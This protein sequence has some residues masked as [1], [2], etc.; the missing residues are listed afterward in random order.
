MNPRRRVVL[1]SNSAWSIAN[2]RGGLIRALLAAKYDVVAVAPADGHVPKIEALGIRFV[3]LAMDNKGTNPIRDFGLFLRILWLLLRKRPAMYLGYTIK[4][5]VYGGLATRLLGI[6]AINNVTG[7]GTAFIRDTWLTRVVEGLYRVGLARS[8]KVFFQNDED[9]VLFL[10]RRL[11]CPE[12]TERLPGSGVDTEWFAPEMYPI[13][14]NSLH[15][16]RNGILNP[17]FCGNDGGEG[18]RP[19]RFLLSARL[20]WDKGVGEFVEAARQLLQEGVSAEFQL[21]GFLDVESR[22]AVSRGEVEAWERE[23]VVRY[24]G[25]VVDVRP[26]ITRADCVV[27]PS[28]YREGVPRSLLEAASMA[29]PIITTDAVGCRDVVGDCVNGYLCRPRDAKDLARQMRRM[30]ALSTEERKKM[31]FAGRKKMVLEFDEKIVIRRYLETIQ[32]NLGK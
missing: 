29:K 30:M 23:G 8:K 20:L 14:P 2:F 18:V 19:F 7:L 31:G 25:S 17:L 4:P 9:R 24:L 3:P 10:A 32:E 13:H 26:V 1:V 22:T 11:V 28:Y 16:G 27:L 15:Q 21:L 5:N 12:V 6:A